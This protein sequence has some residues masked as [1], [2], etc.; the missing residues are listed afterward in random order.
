MH[1]LTRLVL[2]SRNEGKIVELQPLLEPLGIELISQASLDIESVPETGLTFIENAIIK[3]R[4]ASL[5]SGLPA[6][7]D[8]SG[9]SVAGLQG[10][11]GIYSARIAGETA[12]DAEKIAALLKMMEHLSEEQRHAH[13]HCSMAL[14]LS[15]DDPAPLIVE[16][17][18]SGRVLTRS[19]GEQGFGFDPV[20]YIP[21][22]KCTVA[23]LPLTLKNTLSHRAKAVQQL[24]MHLSA[25]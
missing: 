20:F 16:G 17:Q 23:Q 10:A 25:P 11:P 19:S 24:L 12:T 15:A 22:Q 5:R 3:A 4:H 21:D 2:A 9:L 8:D 7:G 6:L 13:Y 14:M 18:W 1:S